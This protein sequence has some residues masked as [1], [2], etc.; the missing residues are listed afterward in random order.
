MAPISPSA[1]AVRATIP[2][3]LR[4]CLCRLAQSAPMRYSNRR[5]VAGVVRTPVMLVERRYFHPGQLQLITR[6]FVLSLQQ[7]P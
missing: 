5:R 3:P 1:F 2:E 4:F 7:L 6:S